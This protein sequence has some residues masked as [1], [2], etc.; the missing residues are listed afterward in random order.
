[1]SDGQCSRRNW[2][3]VLHS[4][5]IVLID[6]DMVGDENHLA[7]SIELDQQNDF[8]SVRPANF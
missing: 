7:G 2:S 5:G 6:V 4:Y 3:Y 8:L 1:M